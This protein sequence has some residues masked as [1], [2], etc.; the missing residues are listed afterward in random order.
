MDRI[1]ATTGCAA[2]STAAAQTLLAAECEGRRLSKA[3]GLRYVHDADPGLKRVRRGAGR[4]AYLDARGA[5]LRD[6]EEILRIRR[7]AI[8]PAYQRVWICAD[9][10][11][12]LQATGYDAR[13]RKQYRYHPDWRV[14]RDAVKFE[15]MVD[16]GAALPKLR[17][18]VA[19]DLAL[20]GLPR[21]KV[22]A[23]LVRLLDTT[24]A[25]IGND[26][27]ARDNRSFG[28]TTLRNRHLRTER[29]GARLRF[30]GKGGT[31]HDIEIDDPRLARIMRRCQ[32]LP[33]QRLFQFLDD[34]GRRHP[35]GSDQVNDYLKDAM[36]ADFTA[37]D[38]RTWGATLRAI[39]LM[40]C[41]PLPESPSERAFKGCIVAAIKQVSVELRNTPAVCRKSYINPLVFTAWRDGRLHEAVGT[42]VGD[43]A[44]RRAEQAALR[45]LKL[46]ARRAAS[47]EPSRPRAPAGRR[48]GASDRSRGPTADRAATARRGR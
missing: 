31:E 26:E 28:L 10:R 3:V 44:P 14:A 17:R 45:F 46:S 23:V 12:H 15:R 22:L 19:R 41:T 4:F 8:P 16:F 29:G 30:K 11:G 6:A 18:R 24:R 40:A 2:A 25:R 36:G 9:P 48:G 37:K 34:D 43:H 5:P 47:A 39:A 27:Y 42:R 13:G 20:P 33:G 32:D 35:V 1:A 7:L 38:F 21:D